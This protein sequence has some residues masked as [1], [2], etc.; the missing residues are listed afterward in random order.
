[1]SKKE[2]I[3]AIGVYLKI[4]VLGNPDWLKFSYSWASSLE[5][6]EEINVIYETNQKGGDLSEHR[7][8]TLP[9]V[10]IKSSNGSNSRECSMYMKVIPQMAH[11]ENYVK[12][13]R[14]C[15]HTSENFFLLEDLTFWKYQSISGHTGMGLNLAQA[16]L[17]K[18]AHFHAASMEYLKVE[19]CTDCI[20]SVSALIGN[21]DVE[22]RMTIAIEMIERHL[23]ELKEIT[24][25][26]RSYLETFQKRLIDLL[27]KQNLPYKV[28][29]LGDASLKNML[30]KFNECGVPDVVKTLTLALLAV[31]DTT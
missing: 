16:A 17:T 6:T 5:D 23:P 26:L 29:A 13:G 24:T 2:L 1:M 30:H 4:E 9:I 10:R 19:N 21:W 14:S 3:H 27:L 31:S 11:G 28:I 22:K 25:K 20:L 12:F 8:C 7:T 18:M 15:I